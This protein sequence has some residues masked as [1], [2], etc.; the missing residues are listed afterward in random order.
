MSRESKLPKG[1]RKATI[2]ELFAYLRPYRAMIALSIAM[3]L[4]SVLCSLLFP[5]LTG[6]AVNAIEL[7]DGYLFFRILLLMVLVALFSFVFGFIMGLVNKRITYSV[8]RDLRERAFMHIQSLPLS[9]LDSHP[10]GDIVSRIVNDTE[11]ISN[12]LLLGFTQLFSGVIT[13]LGTLIILFTINWIVALVVLLLTP[14][15]LLTASFISNKTYSLFSKLSKKRGEEA[16]F[17]DEM[18]NSPREKELFSM[19]K[20]EEEE[21][22]RI[23]KEWAHLSLFS[24]F[25]SSLVNPSTRFINSVVYSLVALSGGLSALFG[26]LSIGSLTATLTY[27][28]Q[29]ARPFSEISGVVTEFQSALASA[30]RLFALINEREEEKDSEDSV[31]INAKG[32]VE[33]ESVSFSYDKSK[34]LIENLSFRAKEGERIAIVG[35]TGCGK[36]TLINLLMRFYEI[37]SGTIKVDGVDIRGIRRASLR[38]Q[39][40]MVLQDT[41]IKTATIRE[42][43]SMGWE[44]A[45][46][47]EVKRVARLSHI[48]R[49]IESLPH[50]YDE[51]ISDDSGFMS[52]GQKQLLSIARAMLSKP[53]MLILDEATSSIDTRTERLISS[54]FDSL[55]EG[56][57][58][59]I[60]AH[61][62]STIENADLIL[63]MRDGKIVESGTHRELIQ[64]NGF[65]HELYYSQFPTRAKP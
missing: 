56:K 60:V 38:D 2:K 21:F 33:V 59:F 24:T 29:Y 14:L 5:Y 63:V 15:S 30:S 19:G 48:D 9:Y 18:I 54:S 27:A 23:D 10:H 43:I 4:L 31:D 12:G 42:N 11:Q 39:Y 32:E 53:K 57:T 61:R 3:A 26:H 58:S 45:P 51:I 40:G 55:M 36:T 6:E 49:F 50:G 1:D 44:D 22:D 8:S 28:S 25:F 7:R 41:W 46:I 16:A 17:I 47:E 62:L 13:I 35:P 20:R 65:Y 37:D 64:K 52:Q 34:K